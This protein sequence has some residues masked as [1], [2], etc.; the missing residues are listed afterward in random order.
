MGDR[1]RV[2]LVGCGTIIPLPGKY[3]TGIVIEHNE[4]WLFDP[5]GDAFL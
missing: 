5:E 4:T 1:P 3:A 2:Q